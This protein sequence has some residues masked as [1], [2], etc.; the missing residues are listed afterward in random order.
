M[1]K[2][3]TSTQAQS[4][5]LGKYMGEINNGGETADDRAAYLRMQ[6]QAGGIANS[7]QG[8]VQRQMA[9]RG[10]AGSGL[11]F[12]LQEQGAQAAANAANAAGV[13]EASQARGRYMDA[14]GKAGGMAG[15]MRGQELQ[16]MSAADA[17]NMFNA[18]QQSDADFRNQQLPQQNFDNAMTKQGAVSNAKNGVA[19]GYERGAADTRQTAG[20]I[21]QA[22]LTA[23]A[24]Y[25]QYGNKKP[26]TDEGDG[27]GEWTYS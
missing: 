11:S 3:T 2:S 23:G 15:Q 22:A 24:A 4:D 16:A 19:V 12:A 7:T 27:F 1:M 6:Q 25:D 21:G 9:N 10:M 26:K 20:G 14:L 8:A 13:N 17:I 18:R 5:V